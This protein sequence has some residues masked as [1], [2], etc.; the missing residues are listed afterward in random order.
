VQHKSDGGEKCCTPHLDEET[1][2]GQ[3]FDTGELE[4]EQSRLQ[5][6]LNVVAEL[7]Q[8]C[9]REN[10]H[11]AL[12]QTEYQARYDGLA[13]RFDRTKAWLDEVGNAITERRAKKEQ[14]EM[15][16]AGP[17]GQDGVV[18]EFD[19]DQWYSMV[20]FDT[21]I[22]VQIFTIINAYLLHL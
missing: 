17:E 13:E 21:Q 15:F 5:E 2:K 8:Q 3:L 1:I 18:T 6:E 12:D 19:E 11:V 9:V 4:A 22:T 20:D 14:I 7:I 16:L 10:A